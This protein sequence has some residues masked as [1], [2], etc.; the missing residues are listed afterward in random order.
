MCTPEPLFREVE[1]W[2]QGCFSKVVKIGLINFW[3]GLFDKGAEEHYP[4]EIF[5]RKI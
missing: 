2:R 4:R 5:M 1:K 3:S